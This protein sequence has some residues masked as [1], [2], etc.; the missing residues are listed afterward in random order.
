LRRIYLNKI[1][2]WKQFKKRKQTEVD[3]VFLLLHREGENYKIKIIKLTFFFVIM[4]N[5]REHK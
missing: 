5:L 1:S 4:R 2:S 3:I